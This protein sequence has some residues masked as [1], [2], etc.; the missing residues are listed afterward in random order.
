MG[1]IFLL[2]CVP[3]DFLLDARYFEFYIVGY[4]ILMHFLCVFCD[5]VVTWN[6]VKLLWGLLLSY[7]SIGAREPLVQ[8]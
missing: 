5:A 6:A 2:L 8:D 7:V 1:H 4:W 3:G